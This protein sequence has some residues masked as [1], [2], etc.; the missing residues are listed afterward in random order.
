LALDPQ[1]PEARK[2]LG[3]VLA[4]Q[5]KLTDA[6]DQ[7]TRALVSS[8]DDPL[9]HANLARALLETG[10]TDQGVQALQ[11]SLQLDPGFVRQLAPMAR[12]LIET[13]QF[14]AARRVLEE[15]L[16]RSANDSALLTL[17]T[18][19]LAGCPDPAQRDLP[20][21]VQVGEQ[22]CDLTGWT[23]PQALDALATA[24]YAVGRFADAVDTARRALELAKQQDLPSLAAGIEARL[25]L[26]QSRLAPPEDP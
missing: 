19:V 4:R 23:D 16:A 3:L 22:A 6:I 7:F 12:H 17:L 25:G 5:G 24:Y 26:Y 9:L 1:Y 11:R 2:H 15:G 13:E 8:P 20:R 10:R 18:R 14:A 21:A